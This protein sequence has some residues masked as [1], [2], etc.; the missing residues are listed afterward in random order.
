MQWRLWRLFQGLDQAV[1][2]RLQVTAKTL[3][4]NARGHQRGEVETVAQ[5][6]DVDGQRVVGPLFAHQGLHALPGA[7][8][9]LGHHRAAV[10]VVEQRAEQ[11]C[12][13]NHAAATLGQGQGGVF[14]PEQG[15]QPRMGRLD[16][17][18]DFPF[19]QVNPQRQGI[20]KHP[21]GPFGALAGLHPA[22]QHGTEHH[23]VTPADLPQHLGKRQVHQA[24]GTDP[25][26]TGL[27]PQTLAQ[28]GVQ[29][30]VGLFDGMAVALH[31]LQAERQRR[32]VYIAEHFPEER[33]V[34]VLADP[35]AGLGDII[36]IGHGDAQLIGLAQQ[37]GL[38]FLLHLVQRGV[39][40]DHM[41][42]QQGRQPALVGRVQ[43]EDQAQHRRLADIQAHPAWIEKRL[44]LLGDIADARIQMDFL[45]AQLGTAPDHLQR[46]V[47]AFPVHGGAQDVMPVDNRLQRVGEI[48][49]AG[50][51][52]K[53]E[54]RLQHIGVALLGAQVVVENAFLQ[55][56][57][58]VDVLHIRRATGHRGHDAV[59]SGLVQAD[60]RQHVRGDALA[61]RGNRIGRNRQVADRAHG[62]CQGGQGRLAEQHADIRRQADLAHAPDQVDRQQR[63]TTEFEEMVMPADAFDLEHIGPEPRQGDFD[64][65]LGR[66]VATADQRRQIRRRQCPT[67]DLAVGGQRETVQGDIG[68]RY[69]VVR[70][71]RLQVGTQG[72]DFQRGVGRAVIGHQALVA[73]VIFTG[74]DHGLLDL[75]MAGQA[76]FDFPQFDTQATD[77]H[78]VVVTP[79]VVE[80]AVGQPARQVAGL[81]HPRLGLAAERVLEEAFGGQCRAVQVTAGHARATDIEFA[82]H[83]HRYRTQLLV[84][85]IDPG[86]GH[87]L[88]DMQRRGVFVDQPG[89]RH[90]R[91]FGRA[92]VVDQGEALALGELS[93]AVAADQQGAQGR[94]LQRLAEGIFGN[95]CRQEADVQRLRQP[96]GQQAVD[97]FTAGL[98]RRQVQGGAD[99]QRRPDFPGHRV[100][101]E[102][103]DAGGLAA[104]FQGERLAVP[105]HQVGQL[106]VLDHHA[107][108]L[109][110][111][112]RGVDHISQ[113]GRGQRG[114]IQV[115]VR[116]RVDT[117]G[118][119]GFGIEQQYRHIRR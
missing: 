63:V 58:R 31:I 53:G 37:P 24:R 69:H 5:I 91:G 2:G 72:F 82:G 75:R 46:L 102:A 84:E 3:R 79:Q 85:Q 27:D 109:T 68:R 62:R 21:Q 34:G 55:R 110:G 32:L 50:A 74:Q 92:V 61:V 57:Q 76:G 12:R 112:A 20:D 41:V 35:Q 36:A 103:G 44:Q 45:D 113:A 116:L 17:V 28:T 96:P 18:T 67:V 107:L 29:G 13:C 71:L 42:E 40:E 14:M 94:V 98:G 10:A 52:V 56:R 99:T 25:K 33:L 101:A 4:T 64:I 73:G 39:V 6:V 80:I 19:T 117:R 93:Q 86:I 105:A 78:L 7:L 95:R 38:H 65:A 43:G 89:G 47:E 26:L 22:E 90:H 104:R 115:V 87:R 1:Q 54:L 15:G 97:I 59:D 81:V 30:Q 118:A 100:E 114:D 119:A 60:Q 88:A 111:G 70:Q 23:L 83:A 49:Q 51:A 9:L 77:L 66:F 106:T 16:P 48:V 11:R 8:A 108:R